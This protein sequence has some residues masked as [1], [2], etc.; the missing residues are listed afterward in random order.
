M[1]NDS[2]NRLMVYYDGSCRSCVRDRQW[3]EKLA[4]RGARDVAWLDITGR[5]ALLHERGIDPDEALM[6]LHVED[7]EGRVH[8]ELDAYVLL[9]SRVPWLKPLAWFLRL[10]GIRSL[11]SSLY[12]RWV[13]D[14]LAS[15][16]RLPGT[17]KR[18][19]Q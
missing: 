18:S 2:S 17:G 7:A 12:Q 15:E 5:D 16:G 9:M 3:Y 6:E 10:P 8:R 4:G 1:V 14:R 19:S 11:F 13:R